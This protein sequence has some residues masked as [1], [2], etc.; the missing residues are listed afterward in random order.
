M[1]NNDTDEEMSALDASRRILKPPQKNK[2]QKLKKYRKFSS[3][4]TQIFNLCSP[5]GLASEL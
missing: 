5:F 3:L 2:K 4:V 1:L